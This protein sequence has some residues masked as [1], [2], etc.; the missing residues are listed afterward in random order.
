MSTLIADVRE[1]LGALVEDL[2]GVSEVATL[3]MIRR[4]DAETISTVPEGW[5]EWNPDNFKAPQPNG[6]VRVKFRNGKE[7]ENNA[8]VWQWRSDGITAE[9]QIIAYKYL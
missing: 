5:I 6:M 4:I 8:G 7:L 2:C 1:L 3:Q 9:T